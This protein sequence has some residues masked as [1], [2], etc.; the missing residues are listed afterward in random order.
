VEE[1]LVVFK[2]NKARRR[3]EIPVEE[4]DQEDREGGKQVEDEKKREGGSDEQI[5][6]ER[7]AAGVRGDCPSRLKLSLHP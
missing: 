3:G 5:G 1:F 4:A 2:A 7:G 6:S